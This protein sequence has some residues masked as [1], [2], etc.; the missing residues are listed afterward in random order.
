METIMNTI[1]K[2]NLAL[3]PGSIES[4]GRTNP[5]ESNLTKY[6]QRQRNVFYVPIALIII[7]AVGALLAPIPVL[8]VVNVIA[9]VANVMACGIIA[10]NLHHA[11]SMIPLPRRS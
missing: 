10:R 3:V 11:I 6:I 5:K 1:Q 4:W 2:L 7:S 9:I 8:C